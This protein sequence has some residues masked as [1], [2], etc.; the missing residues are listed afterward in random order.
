MLTIY[1]KTVDNETRCTHYHLKQDIIAIKFKCC[2]KYYPCYKCHEA[3]ESH[4]VMRWGPEDF[5]EEAILCGLC[6]TEH[7]IN[8]YMK[9]NHC[10]ECDSQFNEHCQN[11]YHLYFEYEKL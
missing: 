9:T 1:G 6:K 2:N 8:E 7:T 10:K 5:S 4:D 3:C 11:H